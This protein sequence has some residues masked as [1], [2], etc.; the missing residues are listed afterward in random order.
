MAKY[1]FNTVA[2][3][4]V[5]DLGQRIAGK[6]FVITGASSGSIGGHTAL[7]LATGKPAAMILLARDAAKVEP[8]IKEIASTSP[9][10]KVSF[11]PIDLASQESVRSAAATIASSVSNIDVII[12]NAGI[13]AG[14]YKT[15][16]EGIESQFGTNHIGH[17]LFT[18]LLLPKVVSG[19]RIV[20]VSSAGHALGA[21]R[22]DD[23]NFQDGKAYEEWEAYGQSKTAN[24]LFAVSLAKKLQARNIKAFSLHPGNAMT[25][26]AGHLAP[27]TDWGVIMKRIS[28]NGIPIPQFKSLDGA[29]ATT[30]AAAI[31]PALEEFSGAY[32]DDCNPAKAT[33]EATSPENAEKLWKL[34]EKLVREQFDY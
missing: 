20:N 21:V 17:F 24:I 27:T 15:T 4:I 16:K 10:T 6:T 3:E 23:Y 33:P 32:L 30:I 9:S 1:G 7:Y 26:L 14:P 8:V 2:S 34:S 22:F 19:G 12:N 11:V 28:D 25:N 13:M 29:C 31:D 18:N 5:A